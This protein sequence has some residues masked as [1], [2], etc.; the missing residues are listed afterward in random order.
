[1][2]DLIFFCSLANLVVV[3]ILFVVYYCLQQSIGEPQI[4][5]VSQSV[6]LC[7]LNAQNLLGYCDQQCCCYYHQRGIALVRSQHLMLI[8]FLFYPPLDSP[9]PFP[10]YT[11]LL[12]LLMF[13]FL[14]A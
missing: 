4:K 5:F 12:L 10:K 13:G 11:E 7:Y 1:M 2:R 3:A 9:L 14:L 8:S 6:G